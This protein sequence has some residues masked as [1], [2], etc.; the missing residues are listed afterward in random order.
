MIVFVEGIVS[1]KHP[2]ELVVESQ[3]I[4]WSLSCSSQTVQ[5]APPIGAR[6]KIFARMLVREGAVDLF[7]FATADE[8]ALFDKLCTVTGIGPRTAL[9]ILGSMSIA[10]LYRALSASDVTALARAQGVGKKTAQRIILEL[11]DKIPQ[12]EGIEGYASPIATGVGDAA[13]EAA[14]ALVSLG[15]SIG[16]AQQA[17]SR[18][19]NARGTSAEDTRTEDIIMDALKLVR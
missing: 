8:R 4:G 2:N 18:A 6:S 15:Y 3:G 1:E 12:P 14:A 11:R 10:D 19:V 9:S 7:G 17:V 5:S 16:E 13:R